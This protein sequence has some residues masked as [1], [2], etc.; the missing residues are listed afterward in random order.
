MR[1]FV[2][3]ALASGMASVCM[4][5]S[6]TPS[7]APPVAQPA[8]ST[9]SGSPTSTSAHQGFLRLAESKG[10]NVTIYTPK[11][12]GKPY[13]PDKEKVEAAVRVMLEGQTK[14][15]LGPLTEVID[16]FEAEFGK[17][18][19]RVFSARGPTDALL[20]VMD[21]PLVHK[22][23]IVLGPAWALAYW[24]RAYVYGE[25]NQFDDEIRELNKALALAPQDPQFNNE[26]G[27]VHIQKR[28]FKEALEAYKTAEQNAE[29]GDDPEAN[30]HFRCVALRGQGYALVELHRLDEAE[31]AYK[32]CLKIKPDEPKSLGELDY[33]KGLRKSS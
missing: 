12:G 20:Y 22:D 19:A 21:G 3:A 4:A 25:M 14:A 10:N 6:A 17:S 27:F 18:P 33:I 11:D 15:P 2:L 29:L 30:I 32:A 1:Q 8:A 9:S 31:K 23:T 26:M 16:R 24:G 7:D 13:D 5:Q 28:Q